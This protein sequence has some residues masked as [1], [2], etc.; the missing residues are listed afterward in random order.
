MKEKGGGACRTRYV[1]ENGGG[2]CVSPLISLLLVFVL[3]ITLPVFMVELGSGCFAK[4]PS[5]QRE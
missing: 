1:K 5:L 3:L 2:A 4:S